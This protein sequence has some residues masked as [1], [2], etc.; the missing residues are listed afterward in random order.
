M[1]G[2]SFVR[3]TKDLLQ[4]QEA[5]G[6]NKKVALIIKIETPEAVKNLPDL[7]FTG[8]REEQRCV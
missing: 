5:M 8:M 7:L 2:Y 1:V 4:L 6:R 3:N